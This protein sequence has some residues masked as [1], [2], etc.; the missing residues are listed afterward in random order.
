MH[1]F[2]TMRVAAAA[3]LA[4][5]DEAAVADAA[6]RIQAF[7]QTTVDAFATL[8]EVACDKGCTY[9]C[10]ISVAASLPEVFL[11]ADRLRDELEPLARFGA[12]AA[13]AVDEQF[14]SEDRFRHHKA[15][16]FLGDD[17]LCTIYS[18]RPLACRGWHSLDVAAC[19]KGFRQGDPTSRSPAL[20]GRMTAAAAI[21]FALCTAAM[22]AGLDGR[23]VRFVAAVRAALDDATWI[24]RWLEGESIPDE[25]VDQDTAEEWSSNDYGPL[26]MS[27]DII[28]RFG[29]LPG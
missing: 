23:P 14:S 24:T 3:R 8:G 19:E 5:G 25:L 28:A 22:D 6:S 2:H 17:D 4:P 29:P 26:A 12:R 21:T 15:C 1:A 27:E 10:H 16:A 11:V 18:V 20:P 13:L 9:C 7:T